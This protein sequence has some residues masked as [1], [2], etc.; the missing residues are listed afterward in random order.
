MNHRGDVRPVVFTD[1]AESFLHAL[2]RRDLNGYGGAARRRWVGRLAVKTD[3]IVK[4]SSK[5][6]HNGIANR[7]VGACNNDNST[8]RLLITR[9]DTS[10]Y[11]H[12]CVSPPNIRFGQGL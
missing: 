3:N 2:V 1:D 4:S 8:F 5:A 10:F 9:F 6:P 7:S 12:S 11:I